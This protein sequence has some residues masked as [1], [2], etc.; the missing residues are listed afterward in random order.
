MSEDKARNLDQEVLGFFKNSFSNR[1]E[2]WKRR[3]LLLIALQTCPNRSKKR[4]C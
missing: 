2:R 1:Y 4:K 3:D